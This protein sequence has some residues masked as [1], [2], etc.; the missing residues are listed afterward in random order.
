MSAPSR[1]PYSSMNASAFTAA[2][3]VFAPGNRSP[4]WPTLMKLAWSVEALTPMSTAPRARFLSWLTRAGSVRS[5]FAFGTPAAPVERPGKRRRP[6]KIIARLNNIREAFTGAPVA[7]VPWLSQSCDVEH[8]PH[9]QSS[10][11]CSLR[12]Q[13]GSRHD[14]S[15]HDPNRGV[16]HGRVVHDSHPG[17]DRDGWDR[18]GCLPVDGGSIG[19]YSDCG[20][21][22]QRHNFGIARG[23][24]RQEHQ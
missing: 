7:D 18:D 3:R 22:A 4:F 15:R 10:H 2:A 16:S 11:R 24:L 17:W 5:C 21:C 12:P 14:P 20:V 1:A 19:G 9:N 8:K 23:R 13:A 6:A